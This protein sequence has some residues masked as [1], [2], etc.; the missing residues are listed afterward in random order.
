MIS[1]HY[2]NAKVMPVRYEVIWGEII[3]INTTTVQTVHIYDQKEHINT[4]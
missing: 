4:F 3:K 1:S 2:S